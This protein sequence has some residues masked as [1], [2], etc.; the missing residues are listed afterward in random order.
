MVNQSKYEILKN[1]DSDLLA[2]ACLSRRE[3]TALN[4]YFR[5]H[6]G[7]GWDGTNYMVLVEYVTK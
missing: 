3:M 5:V 7:V 4:S 6:G 1:A 2:S